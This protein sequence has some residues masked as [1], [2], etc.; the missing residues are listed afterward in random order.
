[1]HHILKVETASLPSL[2]MDLATY[3]RLTAYGL[4]RICG[5]VGAGGRSVPVGRSVGSGGRLRAAWASFLGFE[6]IYITYIIY[7][8]IIYTLYILYMCVWAG[9]CGSGGG[10]CR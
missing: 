1:M 8:M 10:I 5:S 3:L 6:F 7:H 2:F 9:G 4:S